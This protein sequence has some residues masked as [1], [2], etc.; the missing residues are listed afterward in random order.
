MK[1]EHRAPLLGTDLFEVEVGVRAFVAGSYQRGEN[2]VDD[3][4]LLEMPPPELTV[5]VGWDPTDAWSLEAA[6]HHRLERTGQR[7]ANLAQVLDSLSPLATLQRGY[8]IVSDADGKVVTDSAAVSVGERLAAR[9]ARGR[10]GVTV[11]EVIPPRESG[12]ADGGG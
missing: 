5:G 8:A 7:L 4:P 2:R 11:S 9:L 12:R 10:L 3:E 1:E 6:V